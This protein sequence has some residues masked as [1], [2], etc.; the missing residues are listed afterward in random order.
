MSP[1]SAS[2]AVTSFLASNVSPTFKV[3]SSAVIFGAL[4]ITDTAGTT[5]TVISNST[6]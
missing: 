2:V 6:V 4:L 3:L 1:S 5:S